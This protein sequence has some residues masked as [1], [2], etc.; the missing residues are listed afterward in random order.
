MPFYKSPDDKVHFLDSAEFINFLPAG[1]LEITE[2][3]A[4]A[5]SL[6]T[7]TK[8][9]LWEDIKAKRDALTQTSGYQVAGK[10]YHSDTFSRTQQ[11]GLVLMG[12]NIPAGL[13]WK[14]MDGSYVEMTATLAQQVF[15]AAAASDIAIFA[16]AE[17]H[18]AALDTADLQTYDVNTG[19]PVGFVG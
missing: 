4:A 6:P 15:A 19:W 18:R 16:A 14:T 1:S 9:S 2:A 10:W 17:V 3:E 12:S 11:L 7:K 13:Q 8:E 5:L